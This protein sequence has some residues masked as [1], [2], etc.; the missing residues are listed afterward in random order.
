MLHLALFTALSITPQAEPQTARPAPELNLLDGFSAELVYTVPKDEQ[1]SWVSLTLGPKGRIYASDQGDKGIYRIVPATIGEPESTTSVERVGVNV[2]GAQGMCWAFDSLYVNVNGQGLWRLQDTD[3]DDQLDKADN[4]IPLGYGGEHG[5][6]AVLP[7]EDGKGLYFIAGNHTKEPPFEGSRMPANWG[8]DLLLPRQWDAR[9]HAR[10]KLAPGGWIAR[11]DPDG[12]NVEILSIGYRNQYDIALNHQNEM[13]TYDADMEW[14]IGMPWYRPTR[15]CHA[16]SGS[17]FGWRSGTGKW[18]TYYEDSLPPVI[19]IG[20]G[21][22]TGIVF[23]YGANFPA[24]YQEALFILDWTFGTIYAVHL[25]PSGSTYTATKEDFAWSKPLAVTDAIVGADGALYFAVGGRRTQSALY[26]IVYTGEE[27][28]E[29]QAAAAAGARARGRRAMLEEFHGRVDPEAVDTA[30]KQLASPDRFVRYAARLAV[31][32]Q[33]VD[34]W[35]E[36]ALSESDPLASTVALIALA[37]KGTADDLAGVLEALERLSLPELTEEQRLAALRAYALAFVRLGNPNDTQRAA[38]LARLEPLLPAE[39]GATNT[40]LIRV[41]TYLGSET[42]VDKT[43]ALMKQPSEDD[44][45]PWAELIQRNDGYGG[46]IAKMLEVLPPFQNIEYAFMLRN[47][48]AGWTMPK[49]REYFS[50][51]I[52]ASKHSGGMSYAG[53]LENMR[54]EAAEPLSVGQRQSLADV[55]GESLVVPLPDDITP[56]EGPGREWTHSDAVG[57]V[58]DELKE[59]DFDRGR[60]LFH[61]ANCSACHQVRGEGGAIGPD[62]STVANKFSIADLL[63]SIVDPNLAI[64]DQYGSYIVVDKEGDHA[65][66]ILVEREDEVHIYPRDHTSPPVVFERADIEEIKESKTSQMPTGLINQLNA[67]ELKD[68]VA[69]LMS[70]GNK[71]AKVFAKEE[72][73][74]SK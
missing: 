35:R 5:P 67:E 28:T 12:K 27:S 69:F 42:V 61:A 29:P 39:S 16:T 71:K 9:G 36:R 7:T 62:L 50:F 2:S 13:F 49:R 60:N 23:G 8:E 74:D 57:A 34:T 22:P 40:E 21:S 18:P 45:P 70:G 30:W 25:E 31:E 52:D 37:S 59:R 65:E 17:E 24:R 64:S 58:G 33:P 55:L 66:G 10:G 72:A 47:A 14:D 51:F 6:H 53:F 54:S 56:P 38:V 32:S 26:R 63:E 4:L 20:P 44:L 15:L 19:E 48:R 1:G 68:L 41:L 46:P 43:L 73:S 3:D 11:C